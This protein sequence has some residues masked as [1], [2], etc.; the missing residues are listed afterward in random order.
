MWTKN[1]QISTRTISNGQDRLIV[2]DKG[3]LNLKCFKLMSDNNNDY[4]WS[5]LKDHLNNLLWPLSSLD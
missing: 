3:A 1:D 4:W 5:N 2:W